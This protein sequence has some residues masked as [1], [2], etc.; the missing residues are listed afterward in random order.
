MS[1]YMRDGAGADAT[2]RF[3]GVINCNYQPLCFS[4]DLWTILSGELVLTVAGRT[5]C[6][7]AI[8]CMDNIEG[9]DVSPNGRVAVVW[10]SGPVSNA[11]G[12]PTASWLGAYALGGPNASTPLWFTAVSASSWAILDDARIVA[13]LVPA[14]TVVAVLSLAT[15]AVTGTSLDVACAIGSLV[16]SQELPGRLYATCG[17]TVVSL[18]L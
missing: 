12:A 18:Q 8:G 13:V 2:G 11:T 3:Y 16:K 14:P 9:W 6:D 10:Q 5:F 15:G 17:D 7:D 4:L 1:Y